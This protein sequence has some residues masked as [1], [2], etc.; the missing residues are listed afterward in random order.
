MKEKA[1]QHQSLKEY[2]FV[3]RSIYE[4]CETVTDYVAAGSFADLKKNVEYLSEPNYAQL[5]RTVDLKSRFLKGNFIYVS[6]KAFDYLWRVNLNCESII[7]P[8]IGNCGEVYYVVPEKLPYKNNVLATN[9]ILVRSL[10]ESNKYLFYI[11]QSK[12]FQ[13][14]LK[15]ITSPVGQTKFNKTELKNICIPIPSRKVQEE[16]VKILDSFTNLI[17][18]LNEELSLRQK[19]FE[20]YREKLLTFDDNV[21][22]MSL[23]DCCVIK[24]RIGFRGYTIKDQVNKGE[25][26]ISLSPGNISE[27]IIN[28]NQC[29]YISWD[30]YYESPEIMI[31]NGDI[32]FCKTASVGKVAVI[33]DLPC[34]ATINPQLVVLKEI[35][36]NKKYLYY[37]LSSNSIQNKVK[38]L[39]GVGSVPNISQSILNDLDISVPSSQVM[40]SIVEKLDAFESLISS[41]KEEIALRQKQYEYYRE[42][43]LTFD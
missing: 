30:K 22:L 40:K 43:L 29:T 16:I 41:L 12:H 23:G 31:N 34:E 11:F 25:G 10:K 14:E 17:D 2:G 24:G 3:M 27:G 32:I 28:Y 20:Y 21:Y 33:N 6:K 1:I 13:D 18:A 42:K 39:A 5:I 7:L 19:Q 38:S 9:A 4:V 37:Y 36:I 26:A 8:N 35:N 15:K